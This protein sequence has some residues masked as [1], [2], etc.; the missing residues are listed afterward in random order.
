MNN[1]N[2][3]LLKTLIRAYYDD[4]IK[5]T[6][7]NIIKNAENKKGMMDDIS[8]L[9]GVDISD[10]SHFSEEIIKAIEKHQH[11]GEKIIVKIRDCSLGCIDEEGRTLCQKKCEFDAIGVDVRNKCIFIDEEKCIQCGFCIEACSENCIAYKT[12]MFHLL[13]RLKGL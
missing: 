3:D 8:A 5:D 4:C 2:K 10:E 12:D 13:A 7:E 1:Y 11:S 6:I 9:F